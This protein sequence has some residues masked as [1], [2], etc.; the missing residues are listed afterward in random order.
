MDAGMI[1]TDTDI[2]YMNA[3]SGKSYMAAISVSQSIHPGPEARV[4]IPPT[5]HLSIPASVLRPLRSQQ[6]QQELVVPVR[7]LGF[8]CPVAAADCDEGQDRLGRGGHL[9]R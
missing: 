9:E 1:K 7:R 8:V 5:L 2:D 3:F 6:L 4:L